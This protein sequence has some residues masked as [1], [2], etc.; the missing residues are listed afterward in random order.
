MRTLAMEEGSADESLAAMPD[1]AFFEPRLYAEL[2]HLGDDTPKMTIGQLIFAANAE[3]EG[4]FQART[5]AHGVVSLP[6]FGHG[7]TPYLGKLVTV[8]VDKNSLKIG[9]QF[10]A[11]GGESVELVS[12][13]LLPGMAITIVDHVDPVLAAFLEQHLDDPDEFKLISD[14]H[15]HR[16]QIEAALLL[17]KQVRPDF[18]SWLVKSLRSILLFQHPTAES[19]ASIGM[20]GMI[21]LNVPHDAHVG[22]FVEELAHQGGHVVFSEA[23]LSRPDFFLGD[24]DQELSDFIGT[25]DPRTVYDALHGLYT[26]HMESQITL[27]ILLAGLAES[28]SE[29]F[30][31]HL[32]SVMRRHRCDIELFRENASRIF[33]DPG[34]EIFS[35]IEQAYV[36]AAQHLSGQLGHSINPH[37]ASSEGAQ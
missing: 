19:F 24:P 36:D 22:Y 34:R 18:H 20:H 32:S 8:S 28:G 35:V 33:E 9:V 26:E 11:E 2:V 16:E 29:Y 23:T 1:E 37:V 14:V 27:A 17:I 12:D 21:F 7:V 3:R 5:D 13:A 30:E 15:A 25:D 4:K 6:G 10:G 31:G